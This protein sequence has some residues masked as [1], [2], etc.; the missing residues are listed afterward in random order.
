MSDTASRKSPETLR[1]EA[2]GWILRLRDGE[3]ADWVAFEQWMAADS[4][5]PATYWAL[6]DADADVVEALSQPRPEPLAPTLSTR[7]PRRKWIAGG[8]MALA[9]SIMLLFFL[10]RPAGTYTV[11]TVGGAPKNIA[12]DDGSAIFL[13]GGTKL[14][15][16]HA[17]PRTVRLIDGDARFTVAHDEARPFRVHAG[18]AV[19]TD[20]GTIFAVTRHR[21]RL[22]IDVAEGAV[23]YREGDLT[24]DLRAGDRLEIGVDGKPVPGRVDPADVAAWTGGRLVYAGARVETVAADL[25]R[26]TGIDVEAAP[27]TAGLQFSG[28]FSLGNRDAETIRRAASL[29]GLRARAAGDRLILEAPAPDSK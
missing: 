9:A 8:A 3:A 24:R 2:L 19:L 1:E 6:A 20:L 10:M 12:L 17:D 25:V 18:K 27:A 22:R 16:D 29:M 15:L 14:I 21:G 23:R 26:A 4:R 5:A 13:N 28:G 7:A 11:A